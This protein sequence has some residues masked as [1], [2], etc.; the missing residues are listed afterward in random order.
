MQRALTGGKE[1]CLRW[2]EEFDQVE[3]TQ[4]EKEELRFGEAEF[5]GDHESV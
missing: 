5:N 2:Q 4:K 3:H 1:K